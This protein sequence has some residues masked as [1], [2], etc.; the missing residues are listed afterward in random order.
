MSA[1]HNL[2]CGV[3]GCRSRVSHRSKMCETHLCY[4][5]FRLIN[6]KY[7]ESNVLYH[8]VLRCLQAPHVQSELY[9]SIRIV[10]RA[11]IKLQD[12]L[13]GPDGPEKEPNES[14]NK[15]LPSDRASD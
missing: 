6:N 2:I 12:N 10:V 15:N 1:V 7:P 9:L 14:E 13:I 5:V 11:A 4:T 3:I 8:D